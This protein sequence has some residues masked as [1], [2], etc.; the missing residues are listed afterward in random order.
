[1]ARIRL[2]KGEHQRPQET[3]RCQIT[4]AYDAANTT[5]TLKGQCIVPGKRL[6]VAGTLKGNE[7]SERITG[8]WSNPDGIGST[9]I[10]G[11]RR[12]GLIAFNFNAIDPATGQKVAQNIEWRVTSG[13][14]R[15]RS[16]DRANPDIMISDIQ[17]NQ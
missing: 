3:V 2:G 15:L 12:D 4:N 5:L 11:I 13:A 17:F 16:T 14:L 10:V 6:T 1:M 8:R 7:G 9:S